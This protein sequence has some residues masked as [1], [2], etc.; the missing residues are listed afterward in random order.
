MKSLSL[1]VLKTLW[2][3]QSPEQHPLNAVL[4]LFSSG[5]W[6]EDL[7]RFLPAGKTCSSIIYGI[8]VCGVYVYGAETTGDTRPSGA[9]LVNIWY[10]ENPKACHMALRI[11]FRQ[12]KI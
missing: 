3:L 4:I 5:C 1:K 7:M 9:L 10:R 8:L 11:V 12:K 2:T 6:T